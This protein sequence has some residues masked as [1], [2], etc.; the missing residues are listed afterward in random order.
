MKH[1]HAEDQCAQLA[2][3]LT[4]LRTFISERCQSFSLV[5]VLPCDHQNGPSLHVYS[6]REAAAAFGSDGWADTN[7]V[8]WSLKIV[9]GV[10][11]SF[12]IGHDEK[13]KQ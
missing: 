6:Q 13:V 7:A 2:A 11:V 5:C 8:G 10:T 9:D 3:G 1:Q 12:E 4:K